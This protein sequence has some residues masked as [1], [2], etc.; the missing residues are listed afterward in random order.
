MIFNRRLPEK[1]VLNKLATC[2]KYTYLLI[3]NI[4]NTTQVITNTGECSVYKMQQV[5][6]MLLAANTQDIIININPS[7]QYQT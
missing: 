2:C 4:R 3:H 5:L 7:P 6:W 1:Q